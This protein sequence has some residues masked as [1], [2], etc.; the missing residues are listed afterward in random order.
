[1]SSITLN[2]DTS[3]SVQ[4]TVPAVAGSNQVTIA[5]QTGTLNAAG[6]AI[7]YYASTS[8]SLTG[9]TLTKIALDTK[10]FDTTS[11]TF[12][13]STYRFTPNVAG[14]YQVS[15]QV[16]INNTSQARTN[17]AVYKNGTIYKSGSGVPQNGTN[18]ISNSI[19]CLVYM[20]GSTDYIELYALTNGSSSTLGNLTSASDSNY[21]TAVLV[22]GA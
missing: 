4:L 15:G 21:M 20:N 10:D 16:S 6:P 17:I 19:S 14:Y 13:T 22:R 11:S 18:N 8:Q 9:G 7:S 1:M 3:G 12:N 2:G 5:A